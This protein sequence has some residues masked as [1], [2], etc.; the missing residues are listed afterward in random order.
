MYKINDKF[1]VGDGRSIRYISIVEQTT[2]EIKN[3][4]DTWYKV[5]DC[6][7]NEELVL[8]QCYIQQYGIEVSE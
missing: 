8:P 6:E 4:N 3:S 5:R 2:P 7:T 1:A